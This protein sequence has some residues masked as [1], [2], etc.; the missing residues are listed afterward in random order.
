[1]L[2]E[3]SKDPIGHFPLFDEHEMERIRLIYDIKTTSRASASAPKNLRRRVDRVVL[4][5]YLRTSNPSE[6][7]G[8]F[9]MR[10]INERTSVASLSFIAYAHGAGHMY[11][12]YF[13]TL[14]LQ[15]APRLPIAPGQRT[16]HLTQLHTVNSYRDEHYTTSNTICLS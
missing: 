8:I 3:N 6:T 7:S 12:W 5:W 2:K 14:H 4:A 9:S 1:M 13:Y 11:Q 10:R 15:L 16:H